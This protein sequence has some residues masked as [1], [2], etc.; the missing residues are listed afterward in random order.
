M[1]L[2]ITFVHTTLRALTTYLLSRDQSILFYFHLFFFLAL[3]L[4][5]YLLYAQ[6][7]AP[8]DLI[9]LSNIA[10][11]LTVTSYTLYTSTTYTHHGQL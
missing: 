10:K 11:Y 7:F 2:A 8:E 1:P 9:F 4:F 5:S 3:M 6:D